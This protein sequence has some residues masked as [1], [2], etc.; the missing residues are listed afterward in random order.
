[1]R[2]CLGGVT[3]I[4]EVKNMLEVLADV[5]EQSPNFVSPI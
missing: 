5:L 1:V 3:G 4:E 2:V